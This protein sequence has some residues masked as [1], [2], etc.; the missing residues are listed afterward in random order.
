MAR[1]AELQRLKENRAAAKR[2]TTRAFNLLEAALSENKDCLESAQALYERLKTEFRAF[3]IAFDAYE[4]A[5]EDFEDRE[6]DPDYKSMGKYYQEVSKTI[7]S[8]ER[9]LK[10]AKRAVEAR[11]DL[12]N[13]KKAVKAELSIYN[14]QLNEVKVITEAYENMEADELKADSSV[15]VTLFVLCP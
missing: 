15:R 2:K 9:Q 6:N 13:A 7:S 4:R 12:E 11:E 1:D 8:A 10:E 5:L 3:E 14:W